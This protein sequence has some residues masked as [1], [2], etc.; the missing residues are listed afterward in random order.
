[1]AG[2]EVFVRPTLADG[3]SVSVREAIALG[4]VVVASDV[5]TRPPE[6]RLVPAGDAA[7]L[8][9][10]LI[11]AAQELGNKPAPAAATAADPFTFILSLYGFSEDRCAASVAS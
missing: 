7:A 11:S 10:G 1:M 5:G 3:D 8:A 4:R 2:C 6:A 9:N